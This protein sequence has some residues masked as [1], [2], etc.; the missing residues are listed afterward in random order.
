MPNPFNF[1]LYAIE[2]M[3]RTLSVPPELGALEGFFTKNVPSF[4]PHC[5]LCRL[6]REQRPGD[7]NGSLGRGQGS[8]KRLVVRT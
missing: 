7:C 1:L 4:A 6:S 2:I 3:V 5:L 8:V